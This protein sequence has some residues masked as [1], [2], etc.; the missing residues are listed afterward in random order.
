MILSRLRGCKMDEENNDWFFD[1]LGYGEM[2]A[3]SPT[4]WTF[5][6]TSIDL[7]EPS[8]QVKLAM[9]ESEKAVKH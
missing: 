4:S 9:I 2:N 7:T 8:L 3:F 6:K 1:M 5:P